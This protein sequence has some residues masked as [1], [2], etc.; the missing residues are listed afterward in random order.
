MNGYILTV[1]STVI[2]TSFLTA[3]L[4]SGKTA[5]TVKSIAKTVCLI[6]IISPIM[7]F[8]QKGKL[9]TE[10]SLNIFQENGIQTDF[11][12][13]NY[14]SEL[15]VEYAKTMLQNEIQEKF[16][17]QTAVSLDWENQTKSDGYNRVKINGIHVKFCVDIEN[18]T[19]EK[20][21]D[22]LIKTYQ[23]EVLLE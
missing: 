20:V 16:G 23:S 15:S 2:I 17:V 11:D 8:L 21:Q 1:V 22:Y 14:Y 7:S 13:I 3:I 19:K 5:S 18:E 12:F 9:G 10:N 4:P 6:V